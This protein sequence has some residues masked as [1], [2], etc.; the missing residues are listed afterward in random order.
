MNAINFVG[1]FVSK[2]LEAI[3][4]SLILFDMVNDFLLSTN[5]QQ[6][7]DK[8]MPFFSRVMNVLI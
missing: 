8:K 6:T 5:K 7:L 2:E 4:V 3:N 1:V